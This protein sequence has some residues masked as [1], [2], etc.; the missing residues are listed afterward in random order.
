MPECP[1]CKKMFSSYSNLEVHV[2]KKTKCVPFNQSAFSSESA[3]KRLKN[4]KTFICEKCQTNF[5]SKAKLEKHRNAVMTQC[6]IMQ[7]EQRIIDG[8]IVDSEIEIINEVLKNRF[9]EKKQIKLENNKHFS[10]ERCQSNFS[11]KG[12]LKKH[13]NSKL[14]PCYLLYQQKIIN[15]IGECTND[16][17]Q[18]VLPFKKVDKS[19]M[20]LKLDIEKFD[21]VTID[22]SLSYQ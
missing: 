7:L 3:F 10:C 18:I 4:E 11:T 16:E 2:N 17:R 9:G 20:N 6:F 21:R 19:T 5:S 14:T 22:L 13:Q 1:T 12:Q 8:N 15:D